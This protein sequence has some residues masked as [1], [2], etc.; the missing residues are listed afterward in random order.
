MASRALPALASEGGLSR[1]LAEIRKFPLLDPQDEYMLAKRWREH[2]DTEAA[3][4]LVTSE[5]R[6]GLMPCGSSTCS[7]NEAGKKPSSGYKKRQLVR[8]PETGW[9]F[10]NAPSRSAT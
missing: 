3:H 4:K 9:I 5:T 6:S 2:E 1:Y 8:R 10:L 7:L